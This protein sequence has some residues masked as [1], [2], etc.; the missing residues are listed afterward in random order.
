MG[1]DGMWFFPL[2]KDSGSS[3]H[4]LL[5]INYEYTDDGLLH[6]DGFANWSAEKVQKSKNAHG[7]GVLEIRLSGNRWEVVR[8]SKFGRRLTADTPFVLKGP[9]A[10]HP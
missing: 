10:G 8:D 6:R 9:A 3:E 4:G 7:V 1:H 2:P 5:V